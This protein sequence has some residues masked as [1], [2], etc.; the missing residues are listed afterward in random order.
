[1]WDPSLHQT[2]NLFCAQNFSLRKNIGKN[3][4]GLGLGKAFLDMKSKAQ[5]AKE[6]Q[7]NWTP[8]NLKFLRFKRYHQIKR[9]LRIRENICKSYV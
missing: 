1:M 2:Q 5:A 6:K 8:S 7:I 4:H 9:Q 3:L